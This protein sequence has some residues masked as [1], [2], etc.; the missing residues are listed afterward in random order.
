MSA[1]LLLGGL[2]L[3]LASADGPAA[4]S[5]AAEP[6][7]GRMAESTVD[8]ALAELAEQAARQFDQGL[9]LQ[10]AETWRRAIARSPRPR[11][12]YN[13]GQAYRAAGDCAAALDAYRQFLD[14]SSAG[15]PT[16]EA[17]Q[18][19]R[20]EMQDC[21]DRAAATD[22]RTAP[23]TVEDGKG[24]VKSPPPTP[25]TPPTNDPSPSKRARLV[26]WGLIG[27]GVL[28]EVGALVWQ[29]KA[30]RIQSDLDRLPRGGDQM[31][32]TRL[33]AEGRRDARWALASALAGGLLG[34]AGGATLIIY[35]ERAGTPSYTALAG[36]TGAF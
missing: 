22:A 33:W 9:F 32:V 28:A 25:P 16:R 6:D 4:G 26:G 11:L 3:T 27:A 2:L 18:D 34:A 14:R 8:P 5:P 21:V 35:H 23:P 30:M 36:W 7:E 1:T 10:A 15:D 12:F 31:D 19:R 20:G 29:V 24:P 13:L 17:A